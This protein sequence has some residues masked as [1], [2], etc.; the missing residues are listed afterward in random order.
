[1]GI[2]VDGHLVRGAQG[3]AGDLGHVHLPDKQEFLCT[4]GNRGCLEAVASGGAMAKQLRDRGLDA[5]DA[6]HIVS[7]VKAG[8]IEALSLLRR[9]GSMIGEVLATTVNILNPS[10]IVISGDLA[11]AQEHLIAGIREMIYRR[12]LPL[13]TRDLRVAASSSPNTAGIVGAAT[14]ILE[15]ILG[16]SQQGL[17]QH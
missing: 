4:C 9:S 5:P 14:M 13:A 1:M 8:N 7:L 12:S 6:R 11:E 17:T 10:V 16:R 3:A 15:T 2:I